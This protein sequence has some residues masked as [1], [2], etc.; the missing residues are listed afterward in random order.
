MRVRPRSEWVWVDV[1]ELRIVPE[2]L[3]RRVQARLQQRAW[4]PDPA[5]HGAKPKYLLSGL[6]KCGS[7]GGNYV[8][9]FHRANEIHYGCAVHHDRGPTVCR[10]AKLVRLTR[11]EQVT[12][13]YVF[14][15]LFTPT[16]VE[17]LTRAVN[18]A[19]QQAVRQAP[20]VAAQQEAALRQA[21]QELENIAAAIRQGIIT[22]TTRQMQED[23]ERRISILEQAV[24][25]PIRRAARLVSVRTV[26]ERYL[27]NSRATLQTN[28]DEARRMLS[29]ALD[30]IVLKQD[31][32]HFVAEFC[33]NVAG[34]PRLEPEVLGC[35][36]AGSPILTQPSTVIDRRIVA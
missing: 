15:D 24:R 33:G 8:V 17:Y 36:G 30:R 25:Q 22:P 4:T 18:T 6:L 12:L 29:L 34:A 16:R 23:A 1:P 19:L 32:R 35:V 27:R 26:V 21:R 13:D 2:D 5:T 11:I 3:S 9:Q 31:G 28:V 7:C 10:N 14:G 20:S